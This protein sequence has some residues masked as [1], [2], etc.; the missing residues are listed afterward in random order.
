MSE[1]RF[2]VYDTVDDVIVS[3]I[4]KRFSAF[5]RAERYEFCCSDCL[6]KIE[7]LNNRK[8]HGCCGPKVTT[9]YTTKYKDTFHLHLQEHI[10][11]GDEVPEDAWSLELK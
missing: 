8:M 3:V 11:R 4:K 1:D 2:D 6:I 7:M 10:R 5:S 9:D